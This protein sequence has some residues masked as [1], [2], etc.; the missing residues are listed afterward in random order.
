MIALP[1]GKRPFRSVID[2]QHHG[3]AEVNEVATA[4]QRT[5]VERFGIADLMTV[6][7]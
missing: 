1:K 4:M 3:A 7:E 6:A 5:F 2:P